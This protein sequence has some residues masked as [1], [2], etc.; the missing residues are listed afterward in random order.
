MI[1]IYICDDEKPVSERLEHIISNQ[2]TILNGDMGPVRV[3]DTP[4]KL[5]DLQREDRIP[6]VYFLDIDFPGRM[7]GLEL[8]Q[9]LRL[10][11]PRGFIIFITAHND[12]AFETFRLRLEA[13]DYIV[14]GDYNTMAVRVRECLIS[15]QE[16]L[17][18]EQP[19]NGRYCTIRLFD[20]VRHIPVETI[21]YFEALGF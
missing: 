21:L 4:E 3:A 20:T 7:S 16:R 5:L 13:L 12:L 15:I 6:A 8:A 10:H 18:S 19:K 2:I 1:P 14:K 11:D 9:K 17:A